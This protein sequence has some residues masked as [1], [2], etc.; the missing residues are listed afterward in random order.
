[1]TEIHQKGKK[2]HLPGLSRTRK[3]EIHV[4]EYGVNQMG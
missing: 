4:D 2:T 1:M 3:L